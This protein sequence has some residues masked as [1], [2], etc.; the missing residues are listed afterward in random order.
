MDSP[1]ST[2][3]SLLSRTLPPN[4]AAPP[5][6][7]LELVR[8]LLRVRAQRRACRIRLA[9]LSTLEAQAAD[10]L[11]RMLRQRAGTGPCQLRHG[12]LVWGLRPTRPR[13]RLLPGVLSDAA[14][15]HLQ[16]TA[17]HY[18]RSHRAIA[19]RRLLADRHRPEL[20][21]L[22]QAAGLEVSVQPQLFVGRAAATKATP[23]HPI[24]SPKN[25]PLS[26]PL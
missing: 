14:L 11:E 18:V 16:R 8:R 13:I 23:L 7:E 21:A 15:E 6:Q 22:L 24:P 4:A 26:T 3:L 9:Q 25:S 10:A 12:A 2:P 17:P 1:L 5:A 19:R 20:S